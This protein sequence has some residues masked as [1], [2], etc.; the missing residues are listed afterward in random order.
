MVLRVFRHSTLQTYTNYIK[1]NEIFLRFV[2]KYLLTRFYYLLW[3]CKIYELLLCHK[4]KKKTLTHSNRKSLNSKNHVTSKSC[5][6]I[7][8]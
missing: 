7:R 8:S 3:F 4:D 6:P 5:L 2:K 1:K